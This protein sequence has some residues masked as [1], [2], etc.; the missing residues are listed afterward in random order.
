[1]QYLPGI[2][3]L[4]EFEP[5]EQFF[6]RETTVRVEQIMNKKPVVVEA[7]TPI[8]QVVFEM[9][10]EHQRFVYVHEGGALAGMVDRND[11]VSRIIRL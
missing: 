6:K 10:R 5:F 11:I 8:I 2:G 4:N 7:D 1:M 3:F 9:R